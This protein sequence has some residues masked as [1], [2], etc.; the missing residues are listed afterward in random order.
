MISNPIPEEKK[1]TYYGIEKTIKKLEKAT[2]NVFIN[3]CDRT[4][5]YVFTCTSG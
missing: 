4:I 1:T 3:G 5:Y 2:F